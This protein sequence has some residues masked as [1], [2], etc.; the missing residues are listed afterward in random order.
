MPGTVTNPNPNPNLNPNPTV[1]ILSG[2]VEGDAGHIDLPI[3]GKA[4]VTKWRVTRR[5]RSPSLGGTHLTELSLEPKTGR[6]H[7]KPLSLNL[8]PI[9]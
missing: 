3:H 6:N 4:A 9:L 1:A 8:R 7:R 5:G 2:H